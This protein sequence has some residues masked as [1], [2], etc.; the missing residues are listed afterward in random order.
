M[1]ILTNNTCF[2]LSLISETEIL[3]NYWQCFFSLRFLRLRQLNTKKYQIKD[4]KKSC[5]HLRTCLRL[6]TFTYIWG[7]HKKIESIKTRTAKERKK[8]I[9][10][11]SISTNHLVFLPMTSVTENFHNYCVWFLPPQQLN[12]KKN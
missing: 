12:T 8:I 11:K 4:Y 1:S 2:F 10:N 3:H 9:L 7:Q 5:L 6:F